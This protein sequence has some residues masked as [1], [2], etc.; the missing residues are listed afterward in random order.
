MTGPP[1]D[2]RSYARRLGTGYSAFRQALAYRRALEEGREL[3]PGSSIRRPAVSRLEARISP[4]SFRSGRTLFW[5]IE[6]VERFERG[7]GRD[8]SAARAF[9]RGRPPAF[10]PLFANLGAEELGCAA[11]KAG[12]G[13]R[14]R[15]VLLARHGDTSYGLPTLEELGRELGVSRQRVSR[16]QKTAE[17]KVRATLRERG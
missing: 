9:S 2:S 5:S 14:A 8:P 11:D 12:L 3:P 15:L 17:E 7:G 4:V 10:D 13:Q 1:L 6:D 16:I